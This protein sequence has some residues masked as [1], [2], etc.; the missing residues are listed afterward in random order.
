ML[1]NLIEVKV[2]TTLQPLTVVSLIQVALATSLQHLQIASYLNTSWCISTS[3]Q[4]RQ[5]FSLSLQCL[6]WA[7]PR[8]QVVNLYGVSK[9]AILLTYNLL[10]LYLQDLERAKLVSLM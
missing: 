9:A 2:V 7:S 4:M 8:N 5:L 1:V 6:K 3:S 10:Y